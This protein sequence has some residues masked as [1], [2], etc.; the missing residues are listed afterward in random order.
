MV[1]HDELEELQLNL[2]RSHACGLGPQVPCEIV[3]RVL[4]LKAIGLCK[5]HSGV[6]LDTV[7]RILFFYNQDILPII[8]EQGSLGASG[9]LAP[10]AHMS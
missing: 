1:G 5:G 6:Q 4:L 10:L 9:D 8:F 3:K 7:E 2:V